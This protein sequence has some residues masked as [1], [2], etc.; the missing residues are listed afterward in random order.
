MSNTGTWGDKIIIILSTDGVRRHKTWCEHYRSADKYCTRLCHRCIGSA[1][2][3]YYVSKIK[4]VL[5]K[6]PA[7]PSRPRLPVR[8]TIPPP[9]PSPPRP[10]IT[11]EHYRRAGHGDKLLGQTVLLWK[12]AFSFKICEVIR[13]DHREF[14][15][16][17]KDQKQH[18]YVKSTAYNAKSVY[19]FT[20][21][22]QGAEGDDIP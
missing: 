7:S 17:E 15:T 10:Q 3:D 13:E 18:T 11:Q 8:P 6:L 22:I 1:H 9:P 5:P 14:T 16:Y 19:I 21:A 4:E 2:C 20:D 12:D